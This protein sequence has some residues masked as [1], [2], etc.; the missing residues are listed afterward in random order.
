MFAQL[1]IP[2]CF[3]SLFIE[4]WR[5]CTYYKNKTGGLI[6]FYPPFSKSHMIR[7]LNSLPSLKKENTHTG[8]QKFTCKRHKSVVLMLSLHVPTTCIK[9]SCWMVPSQTDGSIQYI[10]RVINKTCS[11][12]CKLSCT[13]CQA[14]VHMCIYLHMHGCNVPCNSVQ[15]CTFGSNDNHKYC[16]QIFF[17]TCTLH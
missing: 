11:N 9:E 6:S 17:Y 7:C 1:S 13:H 14:S 12:D 4:Y 3:W 10:I 15:T 16:L 5:L 8:W 2:T